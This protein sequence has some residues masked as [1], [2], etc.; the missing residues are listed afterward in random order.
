MSKG[1]TAPEPSMDEILSSIRKIIAE[2]EVEESPA[3]APAE[4]EAAAPA[5]EDA[6]A[7]A[8]ADDDILEL[9]EDDE[10]AVED[11]P[12]TDIV[13][14]APAP[15]EPEPA[16]PEMERDPFEL[17]EPPLEADQA[18]VPPPEAETGAA[19][20]APEERPEASADAAV[21]TSEMTEVLLDS[22]TATAAS[23]A[24]Q[25]L[26]AAMSPGAALPEGDRTI[27]AFLADLVRPELKAW[28]DQHLPGLVERIVEREIKKLVRD[29]QPE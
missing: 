28:L 1:E 3:D 21:M 19:P 13:D 9:T 29:A 15:A 2:D 7:E 24:L 5:L 14:D 18:A 22:G 6:E 8:E 10:V 4:P 16:A 25:R 12:A 20:A 17:E 27:E 11:E 26:S 23:G